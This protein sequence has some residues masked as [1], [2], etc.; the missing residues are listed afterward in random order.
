MTFADR[1]R[2]GP[3]NK[4][5]QIINIRSVPLSPILVFLICSIA[6][7]RNSSTTIGEEEQV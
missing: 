6:S 1:S 7:L 3:K 5:Q 2:Q 4:A